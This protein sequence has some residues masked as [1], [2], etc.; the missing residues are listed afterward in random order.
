MKLR[1]YMSFALRLSL[2]R[3]SLIFLWAACPSFLTPTRAR[4]L[5]CL[6]PGAANALF[7]AST[8]AERLGLSL[9]TVAAAT[10]LDSSSRRDRL[11]ANSLP[12]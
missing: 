6:L 8:R 5:E 9:L 4:R 3:R 1:A 7:R 10:R 11:P 12:F 2:L